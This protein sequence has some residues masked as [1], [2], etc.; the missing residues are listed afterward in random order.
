MFSPF[1]HDSILN[2][3][4]CLFFI[5]LSLCSYNITPMVTIYH[6]DL[7]AQ[8][9]EIGG[10][11]NPAIIDYVTD[12]AKI[13]FEQYGDRVKVNHNINNS[14]IST[15][16]STSSLCRCCIES[17]NFHFRIQFEHFLQ[18]SL[19]FFFDYYVFFNC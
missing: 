2:D 5:F 14:L 18:C 13:L 1:Y 4:I 8:I 9:Q 15:L 16:S 6:W 19:L 3:L 17:E 10:W 11:T 12:F 7:P